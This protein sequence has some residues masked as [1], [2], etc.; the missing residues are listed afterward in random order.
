MA[1]NIDVGSYFAN[2]GG[3]NPLRDAFLR[4]SAVM[5][6]RG[7]QRI[8]ANCID[9]LWADILARPSSPQKRL[10]YIHVPF[11]ANHCLFCGFY[12]NAYVPATGAEY[13]DMVIAEI[14]YEAS[15]AAIRENPIHAV[16]LG[17]GTPSALSAQELSRLLSA[18]RTSLP[19][20]S[21][22]EITV[23][24][25]I[26]HFDPEKIDACLEAGANRFSIGVQSFDTDVRRR[27]GRRSSGP[28]AIRFLEAL[29]DRDRAALVID[30]MYGL[31]GQ[32]PEVW[33]QDL[34]TA[35]ALSPDGI[36]L[37]GLNLIPG[38]PLS[39]AIAAGKFPAAP[40]FAD[41]GTFY[42][43][44]SEFF[45]K[46]NWR[47][48]SNNHW[49]RTTRERNLYNLLIKDGADCLA[50]GSGAGGS[51]GDYSYALSG[52]LEQ[53]AADIKAGKK[54]IGMMLQSDRLQ[55]LRS[56]VTAGFEIGYLDL[57]VLDQLAAEDVSPVF[58][59][60][61]GQWQ[62]A[63]LLTFSDDVVRLTVAGRFWYGNLISAF[64]DILSAR[65][66][67]ERNVA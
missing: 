57:R 11:C 33:Q 40:A 46:R 7:K 37:Y 16:Y 34:E 59:P 10:A 6:F 18:V 36:D 50:Y 47:Q 42:R 53:Y 61:L 66:Q 43:A 58:G 63:G 49:G 17:G 28:E 51:I 27:Q 19:L 15:A 29:R 60:L 62:K 55:P 67:P 44:G 54:S 31:P 48:V 21:D 1:E 14:G 26:I 25:R 32:T 9:G 4:R 20:A 64:F 2:I 38:T 52:D 12:R 56:A 35:A 39:T 30:L 8:A 3:G 45:A 41:L 65:L 24:G 5:P 22:C 13:T 23:E